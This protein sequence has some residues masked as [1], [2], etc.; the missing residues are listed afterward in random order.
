MRVTM[1]VLMVSASLPLPL[2]CTCADIVAVEQQETLRREQE[3]S[4]YQADCLRTGQDR[5]DE[6]GRDMVSTEAR[7]ETELKEAMSR[8]TVALNSRV[9]R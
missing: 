8:I 9:C 5:A 2:V 1:L 7:L 6:L 4:N 3:S